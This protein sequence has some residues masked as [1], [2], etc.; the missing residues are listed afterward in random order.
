MTDSRGNIYTR[1]RTAANGG[2]TLRTSIFSCRITTALQPGDIITVSLS[3]S[4]TARAASIDQFANVLHP[5]SIDTQNGLAGTSAAP[6]L[7]VT[8]THANDLIIGMLGVEGDIADTYTEDTLHQWTTLSRQGT[9]GGT[10]DTNVT[11]NGAYR[12]AGTTGTY[13][14]APTLGTSSN[15]IAFL[16]AY[17]AG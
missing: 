7:P 10:P 11:I 5:I 12:A 9:T 2:L 16:M 13:T 15:W 3:A 1:D 4:V 6:S 8:T 14:Y 17:R